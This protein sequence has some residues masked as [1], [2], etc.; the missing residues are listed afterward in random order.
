MDGDLQL[1]RMGEQV[2]LCNHRGNTATWL[3]DIR[4]AATIIICLGRHFI[5]LCNG[6]ALHHIPRRGSTTVDVNSGTTRKVDRSY[7]P[8]AF[9]MSNRRNIHRAHYYIEKDGH[10][11][12]VELDGSVQYS[13]FTDGDS[14]NIVITEN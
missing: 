7:G 10:I 6:C 3:L 8:Y 4:K 1:F 2:S 5:L 14:D 13:E 12:L 11:Y 9:T